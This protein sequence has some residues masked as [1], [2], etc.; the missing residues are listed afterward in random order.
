M[1]TR[2]VFARAYPADVDSRGYPRSWRH[3]VYGMAV[4]QREHARESL[5]VAS[6]MRAGFGSGVKVDEW[7]ALKNAEAGW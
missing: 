6:A 7:F 1:E 2:F 3:Y 5:R 4:L